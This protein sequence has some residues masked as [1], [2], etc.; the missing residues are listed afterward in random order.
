MR[1]SEW[2]FI[3]LGSWFA[4]IEFL[5]YI[6]CFSFHE[7]FFVFWS[8]IKKRELIYDFQK[9][10][11][12]SIFVNCCI[13]IHQW[14]RIF[15]Q[16][17]LAYEDQMFWYLSKKET[18]YT[19]SYI[20]ISELRYLFKF[21]QPSYYSVQNL[22]SYFN[23]VKNVMTIRQEID[24]CQIYSTF[25]W[26]VLLFKSKLMLFKLLHEYSF[27]QRELGYIFNF[28]WLTCYQNQMSSSILTLCKLLHAYSSL[29]FTTFLDRKCYLRS[30]C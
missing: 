19:S 27:I 2:T 4:V 12:M 14:M 20:F 3:V 24:I 26:L 11:Y 22:C 13:H 28:P 9:V 25:S 15:I 21:S 23:A 7:Q 5:R 10:D 6:N 29:N 18:V 30:N 16:I 8:N 1:S 17:F